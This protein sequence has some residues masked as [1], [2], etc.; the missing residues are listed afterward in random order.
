[1]KLLQR[2]RWVPGIL[3]VGS[4][5]LSLLFPHGARAADYGRISGS[6]SDSQGNPLMGATVV[7]VGPL[8]DSL[9]PAGSAMERVITD[10][11]GEFAV[12]RLA[13]GWYSLKVTSATRLPVMRNGIRVEAGNSVLQNFVLSDFLAPLLLRV[14]SGD[15]SNWGENWKWVLRTSASTRPI[16]RLREASK[17]SKSKTSKAPLPS[18]QRLVA[19]IP[20]AARGKALAGDPGM[21]SVLAYLRPLSADTDLLVAG[22]MGAGGPQSST[23]AAMLRRDVLKGDPQELSLVVHQLDFSDGLPIAAM[24]GREGLTR[25]QGMVAS[26]SQTRR[27]SDSVSVSAGFEADYLNAGQSAFSL[28]PSAKLEYRPTPSNLFALRYGAVRVDAGGSLLERVGVLTAFPRVT[29]R[30]FRPQLE[31][32]NHSE[33]SYTRILNKTSRVELA[34][35]RDV[36]QNAAVWGFGG[37][38]VLGAFAGDFLPNPAGNGVTLNGGNFSSSGVRMAFARNLGDRVQVAALYALGDALT[39]EPGDYGLPP[40]PVDDLRSVLRRR[41]TQ[42][43][44][45]RV[46]TLLP[47]TRT[48]ITT[49]YQWMPRDRVTE[50]DPYGQASM[51]VQPYLGIQIRQPLPKLAFLPA[52]IEALADF[53]NLLAQGYTPVCQS[54]DDALV[55]TPVYRSFRGGFSVQF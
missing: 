25:A 11:H 3:C 49:S 24:G 10:A 47:G 13:P 1:M 17:R 19:M 6:V 29:L 51:E 54:G 20:G 55:L 23:V 39:A 40:N 48:R 36:L 52:K 30:G 44:G 22:S 35:Y 50:V 7:I 8:F 31:Q 45:G 18:S 37:P 26:Y 5:V 2:Q 38:G 27:L 15:V 16:L 43:V 34:A 33:F 53:S 9:Q 46:I 12:E 42:T 41:Q 21:G 32:L 14:P 28:R 4:L